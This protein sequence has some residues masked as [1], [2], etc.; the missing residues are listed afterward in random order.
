MKF[1]ISLAFLFLVFHSSLS[2]ADDNN[3]D[4]ITFTLNKS[5][6]TLPCITIFS[7]QPKDSLLDRNIQ[8]PSITT[9]NKH[10]NLIS[11]SSI[12][13]ED[14]SDSY[15]DDYILSGSRQLF[16]DLL[17]NVRY[18]YL[19]SN[20]S[21]REEYFLNIKPSRFKNSASNFTANP[22]YKKL[23]N[24]AISY[25]RHLGAL[26]VLES[27]TPINTWKDNKVIKN[28]HS[29]Q[30]PDEMSLYLTSVVQKKSVEEIKNEYGSK[31]KDFEVNPNII[32]NAIVI[33]SK[34][35][36]GFYAL[37]SGEIQNFLY[38]IQEY[39]HETHDR[40]KFTTSN[41]FA[42][43]VVTEAGM[44]FS[45]GEPIS[46]GDCSTAADKLLR[47]RVKKIV[48]TNSAIIALLEDNTVTSWGSKYLGGDSSMLE[49]ELHDIVALYPG[50]YSC[51][52]LRKDKD[53]FFWGYIPELSKKYLKKIQKK[54]H[55]ITS[56]TQTEFGAYALTFEDGS[57]FTFGGKN[58]E[59]D[60]DVSSQVRDVEYI[61]PIL[62]G[63][64][65][66]TKNN[67]AY[68]WG[69]IDYSTLNILVSYENVKEIVSNGRAF[70]IVH[71]DGTVSTI[72]DA[73]FGGNINRFEDALKNVE[74]I[75]PTSDGFIAYKED[76][77]QIRWDY[78]IIEDND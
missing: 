63:F 46:G 40:I 45:Y 26:E 55:N 53:G 6:A 41:A 61:I 12:T 8:I 51:L 25:T 66:K 30:D 15:L 77:T 44:V 3:I 23:L 43:T 67:Q 48:S 4:E 37:T 50:Y 52:A 32:H 54:L 13:R 75:E 29:I 38:F 27:S 1:L 69:N 58:N 14:G 73:E 11:V 31:F 17:L 74:R 42:I 65:L 22:S 62:G 72:G 34:N 35:G 78:D 7:K 2:F 60:E 20:S 57:F 18:R 28:I 71:L 47:S 56:I 5:T 16:A 59:I 49:E 39:C 33:L 19:L 9:E 68:I 10:D 24:T 76:G 70:A 36:E 21:D 64:G